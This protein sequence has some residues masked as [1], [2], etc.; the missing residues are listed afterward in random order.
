MSFRKQIAALFTGALFGVGLY[1]SGM[2]D[3][4]KVQDFP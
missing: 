3:P 2:I 4:R 1:L